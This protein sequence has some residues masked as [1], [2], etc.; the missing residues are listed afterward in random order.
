[1]RKAQAFP[2]E[3]API[4]HPI[5]LAEFLYP[6]GMFGPILLLVTVIL[7]A[8]LLM[9]FVRTRTLS[10]YIA[11]IAATLY[12]LLLGFLGSVLGLI[13]AIYYLGDNG[14]DSDQVF[15]LHMSDAIFRMAG[16]SLLT[17]IF[18]PLGILALL[19]RRPK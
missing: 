5:T 8:W 14:I 16:A 2:V 4:K 12:P 3:F 15:M 1:M 9:L 17:C 6:L 10:E 18:F 7:V 11:Y 19:I 13:R